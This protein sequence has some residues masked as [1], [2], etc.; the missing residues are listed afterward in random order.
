MANSELNTLWAAHRRM[1][2]PSAARGAEVRG[3]DLVLLDSLAAGC[4]SWLVDPAQE[5]DPSKLTL[6]TELAQQIRDV[7]RQLDGES[8]KYFT[9]LSEVAEAVLRTGTHRV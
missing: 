4:I 7:S 9:H 2:F 5:G 8:K 1:P 3:V 6:F